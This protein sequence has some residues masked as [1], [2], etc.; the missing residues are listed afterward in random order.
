MKAQHEHREQQITCVLKNKTE[1]PEPCCHLVYFN[2]M[3]DK[4]IESFVPQY[5]QASVPIFG[6][7]V[8]K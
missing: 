4:S 2:G 5:L 1:L 6:T 8:S 7:I 3:S